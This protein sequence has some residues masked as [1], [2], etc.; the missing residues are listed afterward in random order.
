MAEVVTATSPPQVLRPPR[1]LEELSGRIDQLVP[2]AMNDFA[3]V[4]QKSV[5]TTAFGE[6]VRDFR[7]ATRRG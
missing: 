1:V 2:P 5:P 4:W 7:G 3:H 6:Y